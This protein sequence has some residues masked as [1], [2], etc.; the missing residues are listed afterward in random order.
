LPSPLFTHGSWPNFLLYI[1][2]HDK[3]SNLIEEMINNKNHY[4]PLMF[5]F[6][7]ID[8]V[9]KNY[10][11]GRDEYSIFLYFLITFG[12]WYKRHILN[13]TD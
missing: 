10:I 11:N 8:N 6:N 4:F 5:D 13:C 9:Y 2:Y 7:G 1:R 3:M 12:T